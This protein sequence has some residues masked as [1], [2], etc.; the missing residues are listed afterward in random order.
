MSL[1]QRTEVLMTVDGQLVF[2]LEAGDVVTVRR[3]PSCA[4]IV[5]ARRRNFYDVLRNKLNWSGGPDPDA[6]PSVAASRSGS[7]EARDA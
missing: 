2:P 6:W 3:S 5:R 7:A 4:R 1:L